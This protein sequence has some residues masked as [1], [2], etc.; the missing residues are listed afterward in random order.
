[1][2]LGLLVYDL[3]YMILCFALYGAALIVGGRAGLEAARFVPWALALMGGATVA[4]LALIAEVALLTALLPRLR[5]GRHAMMKG[6]F[7]VWI[8]RSMLRRV[9]FL[10]GLKFVI[11]SSNLL[12]FFALRALGARVAFT[13]NVSTDAD[14][15]DPSLLRLGAGATV[16]ARC[17]LSGHYV[18]GGELI[19]GEIVI[20]RG[21][22]LAAEV[23]VGPSVTVGERAFVKARAALSMGVTVGDG[24][25]VGGE[26]GLDRN[27][28]VGARS[29]VGSRGYVG[30]RAELPDGGEV[31]AL[32]VFERALEKSN[33]GSKE[34]A[35][36]GGPGA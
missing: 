27:A 7:L 5:S 18:E 22:L 10:P 12:R 11:F 6:M 31:A 21:A 30:P 36:S 23:L 15:L 1:M 34:P 2:V 13:A 17:L 26:A 32:G 28:R 4:L 19:L 25:D 33:D 20:S 9:L 14:L 24:A 16:G 3:L 8:L 29:R 35:D